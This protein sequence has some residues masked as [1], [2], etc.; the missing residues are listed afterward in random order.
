M[1]RIEE[2]QVIDVLTAGTFIKN[3]QYASRALKDEAE[4][5]SNQILNLVIEMAQK[6]IQ[7]VDYTFMTDLLILVLNKPALRDADRAQI[8]KS[9]FSIFED[10]SQQYEE[11][12]EIVKMK[13][14]LAERYS[15]VART[16]R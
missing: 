12:E 2:K 11:F 8:V 5:V 16:S 6:R 7:L 14:Y 13:R 1:G 15:F 9:L 4:A 10:K 3:S